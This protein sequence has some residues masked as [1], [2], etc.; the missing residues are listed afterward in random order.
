[1][2]ILEEKAIDLMNY[3]D[4]INLK[5]GG[6]VLEIFNI[7]LKFKKICMQNKLQL[8]DAEV[9]HLGTDKNYIVLE[10]LYDL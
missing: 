5:Y 7:R 4:E 6:K 2:N 1:M 10:N 9:R 3:V 8:L